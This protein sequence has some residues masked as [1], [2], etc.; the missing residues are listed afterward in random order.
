MANGIKLVKL[1]AMKSIIL[2]GGEGT[3]LRPLTYS[4]VKSMVPVVNRPFIE[5]VISRLALH[6]IREI[7][8]AMGYKPDSIF[9]YFKNGAGT[10]LKLRYSME[11]RPLGTAGA[12][13]NVA[14]DQDSTF[15]VL[16]GDVFSDIDYTG[17]LNF[18]MQN[19]AMATIALTY[20]ED[21]TKFGVVET[22]STGRV[23]RFVEKPKLEEVTSHWINAGVYIL[24]PQVL[25]YI[26][27][28]QPY[29]FETG[30][31]PAMLDKAE[32]VFAYPSTAYWIDMGTPEK[33]H[34]LN[35]DILS[36]RCSSP[37]YKAQPVT[38]DP[39]ANI[40]PS[41]RLTAPVMIGAN[42]NIAEGVELTGPV[43]LGK[44]CIINR[45]SRLQNTVLW[46]NIFV[47]ETSS[48]TNSIIASGAKIKDKSCL[49]GQ[50]INPE[51]P[52]DPGGK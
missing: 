34:Q 31:F 33:Y 5:H 46:D 30:V 39:S 1:P 29:M 4:V 26:P 52:A 42:C 20:V 21:P 36:G 48:I 19:R 40:H 8:L 15:F 7:V 25:N 2:V 17:M 43:I 24:E 14:E 22:D 13:K 41:A 38:A 35:N 32:R 16:N 18:H 45:N 28:G 47:G 51:A 50:T 10:D 27:Q 9:Q 6:N 3:R 44:G 11:E 37:L 12:V 23:K 49:D